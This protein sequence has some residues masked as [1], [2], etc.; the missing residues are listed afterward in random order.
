MKWRTEPREPIP[1]A[2]KVKISGERVL[3]CFPIGPSLGIA[4]GKKLTQALGD[5]IPSQDELDAL[6]AKAQAGE[7]DGAAEELSPTIVLAHAFF[8]L[9]ADPD[10][11][12][13]E[14]QIPDNPK[15]MTGEELVQFGLAIERE[16]EGRLGRR[17]FRFG[18]VVSVMHT[19]MGAIGKTVDAE[20]NG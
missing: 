15:T 13:F 18:D 3:E 9:C 5:R 4:L 19:V 16:L 1:A 6:K 2:V 10:E 11:V 20:K 12:E 14:T 8:G 17:F 7:I